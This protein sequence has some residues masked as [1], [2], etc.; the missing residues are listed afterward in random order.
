MKVIGLHSY[1]R[2]CSAVLPEQQVNSLH[3]CVFTFEQLKT[4]TFFVCGK[5]LHWT[6][7]LERSLFSILIFLV[8]TVV[9]WVDTKYWRLPGCASTG[10]PDALLHRIHCL[11]LICTLFVCHT[12]FSDWFPCGTNKFTLSNVDSSSSF[13]SLMDGNNDELDTFSA[14]FSF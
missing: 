11:A 13:P 4:F 3:L 9:N 6:C 12:R 8:Q 5:Y 1:W 14:K 10:M 7:L 2:Q